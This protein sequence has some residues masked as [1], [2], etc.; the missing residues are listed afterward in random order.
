MQRVP[1]E[2]PEQRPQSSNPPLSNPVQALKHGPS[3]LHLLRPVDP[4]GSGSPSPRS[5][6]NGRR[7]S[8]DALDARQLREQLRGLKPADGTS[9]GSSRPAVGQR[10]LDYENALTPAT[11]KQSIGFKVVRRSGSSSGTQL[12]DFPNEILTHILSH[13][14]PDSHASVALVSKRFYALVT[15]PHAWRMAFMR[16]FSGHITLQ[17]GPTEADAEAGAEAFDR[18]R[19]ETRYFGR[20]T[21]LA[22]WRSE[23][24]F[25]TRLIRSLA[26]G[27]PGTSSGSIGSSGRT[28]LSGKKNSAVLTYNSKLPWLVT[29]IHAVLSNGKKSPRVI[30]GAGDLGVATLSDPTSGK[31]EK[32]G[33]EDPYMATHLQEAMPNIVPYGL[34]EGA[35]AAPNVMDV[36]Q[37]H[38]VL[39]GEG[40]P[41]G[42]AYFRGVSDM[43][44]RYLGAEGG[45]VDAYPEIPRIPETLEAVC[46]V[47][48]AKSSAVPANT[49]SMCGMFTGSSLGVVTAYS[50]GWDHSGPRYAAGDMTARW[51]V[52]PGVPIISLKIDDGYSVKRKSSSRVWAVALTALGEVYYLTEALATTVNRANDDDLLRHAW[53]AGRSARWRLIEDTRRVARSNEV[54]RG[55]VRDACPSHFPSHATEPSQEQLIAEA[56]GIEHCMRQTPAHFREQYVGWD[57]QRRLEV[58]FAADDCHG[59]GEGIFVIDCGLAE[60]RPARI[61]RLA[62]SVMSMM[63]TQDIKPAELATSPVRTAPSIFGSEETNPTVAGSQSP[64]LSAPTS[65]RMSQPSAALHDWRRSILEL[66]GHSH[67]VISASGM[68]CSSHSL[69]TLGE[70]PL[71]VAKETGVTPNSASKEDLVTGEIP[72]RRARLLAVGTKGGAII[73]WNARH[74][75]GLK[76]IL[77]LRIIQTDSPAI[78]CL[79]ASALYLVH[80]GSDGLVQA[81]DPLASTRDPLRTLNARSNGRVPHHMLAMN[82][83]LRGANYSA[84][85]AIYLD[86]DPTVLRGVVSFGAFLRYWSYSSASHPTGRKRRLRHSDIHGRL[87]SRRLG[88][89]V[90]GYIAA[91]EAEIRRENEQRAREQ[92]RL[93]KRFG[94]GALGDLTEQEALRYAQMVSEEAFLQDEQRRASDSAAD[95]SVDTASS[96]SETTADTVTPEPSV[97][98]QIQQAIRLS[99]LEGVNGAVQSPRGNSPGEFEFS[100]KYKTQGGRRS[101]R[102]G[103]ASPSPSANH[104]PMNG[105]ESG[106]SLFAAAQDEDE[107]LA[108]AL[109]LSMQELEQRRQRDDFPPLDSDGFGKGKGQRWR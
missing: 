15:T 80:G 109:S 55:A 17:S 49:Q 86:S 38:G 100:I 53:S 32:W 1:S 2:S 9:D 91:E 41:G 63:Q 11:P 42:R 99:L 30:H 67:A 64:P 25:R 14:H 79:A 39:L 37:P 36:S 22:T 47:W 75:D 46:S 66:T 90:S 52:S 19:L 81:W 108:L 44:G 104:T 97:A 88:G 40:F 76:D 21:C 20:L 61:C 16:Y 51:V 56:R 68:D 18:V 10:I 92:A 27:K 60:G 26:R 33:L 85:G 98:A 71:H 83:A 7:G 70:D 12:A 74:S 65:R 78:T 43:S 73:A 59:A 35:A 58:D 105:A 3:H 95:A 77:P 69:L 5:V 82:P 31:I 101:K 57:M 106:P 102:S 8:L 23:Y 93:H 50:L 96:F 72:G 6:L 34:G 13:L 103:S 45:A 28:I 87:A 107:D 24:I 89:A 54:D 62:R 94:V 29:N 84:A 48:I 4:P